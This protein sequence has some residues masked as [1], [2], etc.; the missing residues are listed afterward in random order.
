MKKSAEKSAA[1][2]LKSGSAFS[3]W[4]LSVSA[5]AFGILKSALMLRKL[6]MKDNLMY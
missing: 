5:S 2:W 1:L 6:N 3:V 4:L